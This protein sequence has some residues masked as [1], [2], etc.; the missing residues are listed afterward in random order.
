MTTLMEYFQKYI[1]KHSYYACW[2]HQGIG[3]VYRG[4][5]HPRNSGLAG[6]SGHLLPRVLP[7]QVRATCCSVDLSFRSFI[8]TRQTGRH[9]VQTAAIWPL[10]CPRWLTL[11][12]LDVTDR[13]AI[14]LF[15]RALARN[16]EV[17]DLHR[18]AHLFR[19]LER[20]HRRMVDEVRPK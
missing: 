12:G 13:D 5:A 1:P 20:G 7:V 10:S 14:S 11:L 18:D 15:K 16:V 9:R 6:R 4:E 2:F 8:G 17:K 3:A 19:L